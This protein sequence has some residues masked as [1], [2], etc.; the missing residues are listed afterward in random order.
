MKNYVYAD[1]AATTKVD[2]IAYDAMTPYLLE[3]FGNASAPYAFARE[4]K[5]ALM[6]SREIIASC[7]GASPDEIFFTSGGTESDNWAIKGIALS[8]RVKN[9]VVTSSF[10]HHAVL[11]SC[12]VLERHGYNVAY[13]QP[14]KDGFITSEALTDA[15]KETTG[16]TSIMFANNEIGS[17]QPIKD[18]CDIAHSQDSLFHT[19]AVQVVGHMR[20]DVKD[21]GVDLLSASAHK[22]NGM[23][24]CGFLYVRKGCELSSYADGGRQEFGRRAGTENIA[25]IVCMAAALKNNCDHIDE[26]EKRIQALEDELLKRLRDSGISFVRNGGNYTLTGLVNLS[27]PGAD[28]E[29]ILHR[30]DLMGICISTGSA[31]NSK[32]TE[33]SHVLRA[34]KLDEKYAKG[35]IRISL[36]KNN[37]MEDVKRIADG[38]IKI[39]V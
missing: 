5:K 18:L 35:A 36:G 20:I 32:D 1:N 3:K 34:I 7:I 14:S 21:L 33:I 37:A 24:G 16:L 39:L 10:E 22:F 26:N 6:E 17:I 4:S 13:V 28:G 27:F 2:K 31:C 12:E 38:L 8:G 19:D 30:M 29:A 15:L 25:G 23:K 11:R 9:R